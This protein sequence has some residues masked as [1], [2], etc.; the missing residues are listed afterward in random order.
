MSYHWRTPSFAMVRVGVL[1]LAALVMATA[2]AAQMQL[3]PQT[4]KA[5]A[6]GLLELADQPATHVGYTFD[7]S[8]MQLARSV[9]Q[10]GGLDADRAAAALTGL[11]FDTYRYKQPAFYT[12]ETMASIVE[13]YHRAGW[14]HLVNGNQTPANSAQPHTPITDLW[15]HFNGADIDHVTVLVRSSRDMNLV[16]I[17]GDLRPL[18]LIHLSGHFGIPKVDP[19]AVMVPAPDSGH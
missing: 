14:K 3:D 9:L 18:D 15:L 10:S 13:A 7:R 12:P 17:A 11:S 4:P 8:Q 6:D 19:N 5:V 1:A 2:A 16:Q